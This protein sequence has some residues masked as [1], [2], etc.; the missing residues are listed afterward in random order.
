M[1]G[2][3]PSEPPRAADPA[4]PAK[5]AAAGSRAK[6]AKTTAPSEDREA[7]VAQPPEPRDLTGAFR[8]VLILDPGFRSLT[9][10]HYNNNLSIVRAAKQSGVDVRILSGDSLASAGEI[11]AHVERFFASDLYGGANFFQASWELDSWLV[12]NGQF[13]RDLAR[14]PSGLLDWADLILVT[15]I[16]QFHVHALSQFLASTLDRRP[17]QRAAVNLM[18]SPTWT[19]WDSVCVSGPQ[20]Y[21]EGLSHISRFAGSRVA[22]FSELR[23]SCREFESLLDV[24][25]DVMPHPGIWP[26]LSALRGSARSRA[27]QPVRVGYFGYA[28]REKG[29]HL[30]PGVYER[31][32]RK[33]DAA[34]AEFVVHV[35]HGGYDGEIIA[36]DAALTAQ[37]ETGLRLIRGAIS[38]DAYLREFSDSDIILLPYDPELYRGRGSG[39]FSEA[40]GFGKVL[41]APRAAGVGEEVEAGHGAGVLFD[42]HT[43]QEVADAVIAAL[44]NYKTLGSAAEKLATPWRNS[45]SG[46]AVLGII[47]DALGQQG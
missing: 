9:G 16:T 38:S 25:V 26:E 4:A 45:H 14:I 6:R 30:M 19:A 28:K 36:A 10:H 47:A 12:V 2:T 17:K 44:A 7:T 31:V 27:G 35:N 37:P 13:A 1:S 22:Y 41:I 24:R 8:N 11:D 20:M 15:A 29:F 32:R 21:Q 46:G 23:A 33:F 43:E 18:F 42:Q 3:E 34:A 5:R 39:V 40:I